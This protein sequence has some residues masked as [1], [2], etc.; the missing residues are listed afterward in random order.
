MYLREFHN[1]ILVHN[2]LLDKWGIIR[3]KSLLHIKEITQ[4][5]KFMNKITLGKKVAT[6]NGPFG[7]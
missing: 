7:H 2:K 3:F 4:V 5:A 1:N 6:L